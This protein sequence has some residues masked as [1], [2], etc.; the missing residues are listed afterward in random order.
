MPGGGRQSGWREGMVPSAMEVVCFIAAL[1]ESCGCSVAVDTRKPSEGGR[2]G[3]HE[4]DKT[5]DNKAGG[6]AAGPERGPVVERS[7]WL[8]WQK[9]RPWDSVRKKRRGICGLPTFL[10]AVLA[11]MK[12]EW[13][14]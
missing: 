5:Q 2:N 12:N 13:E 1:K 8:G 7:R 4:K 11:E 14:E 6:M 3:S 10:C 9:R